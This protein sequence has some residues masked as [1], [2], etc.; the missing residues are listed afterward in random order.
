MN[1]LPFIVA[2][3]A[4]AI[5]VP[6]TLAAMAWLRMRRVERRLAALDPRALRRAAGRRRRGMAH[7]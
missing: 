4:I 6:A 1:P 7:E 3:Y 5:V 2:S